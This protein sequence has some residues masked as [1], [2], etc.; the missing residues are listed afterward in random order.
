LLDRKRAAIFH[1]AKEATVGLLES[2]ILAKLGRLDISQQVMAGVLDVS[3]TYLS[4]GLKGVK[5]LSGPDLLHIDQVLNN[6]IDLA[7][8]IRPFELPRT[9]TALLK[10]LL[11]RYEDN[12][13]AELRHVDALMSLRSQIR[14]LQRA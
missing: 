6:L 9:D 11:G 4:R 12:G 3:E 1:A 10:M 5:P 8:I 13:M 2:N 7:E 14:D